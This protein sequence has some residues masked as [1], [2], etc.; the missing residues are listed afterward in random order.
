MN[1]NERALLEKIDSSSKGLVS[2]KLKTLVSA[3]GFQA[4]HQV[5]ERSLEAT[6]ARLSELGIAF[7]LVSGRSAN[8]YVSLWRTA[9]VVP[10]IELASE[11]KAR[12]SRADWP[13]RAL[14]IRAPFIDWILDGKK[15]WEIRGKATDMRGPIGLIQSGS[16]LIVG[17]CEVVD[18]RGP[19]TAANLR[20]NADKLNERPEE[21]G[22][23]LHYDTTYAWVLARAR[24][25]A[26]P[27]RY[28]H[29]SGAVIWV[30]LTEAQSRAVGENR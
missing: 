22:D 21:I 17:A 6:L 2:M 24:R 15:T 11:R 14:L 30:R 10:P 4:D 8:D 18:I 16:G 26:R 28:Q 7:R 1:D 29:P 23:D 9:A 27:V 25:L 20:A 3:F 12:E 5:R 19:L 13:T